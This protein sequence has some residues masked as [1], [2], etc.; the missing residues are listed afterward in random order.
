MSV[1]TS[2][3]LKK[4]PGGG[5][6]GH[7]HVVWLVLGSCSCTSMTQAKST[8]KNE[9]LSWKTVPKPEHIEHQL[10][11]PKYNKACRM[12]IIES[13]FGVKAA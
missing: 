9:I 3:Y 6:G 13:D 11:R 2:V 8:I 10:S 4:F 1:L 5:G 7:C 12:I